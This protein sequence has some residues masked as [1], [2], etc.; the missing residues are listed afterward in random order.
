SII[1]IPPGRVSLGDSYHRFTHIAGIPLPRGIEPLVVDVQPA[2]GI[3]WHTVTLPA[4]DLTR[5]V[6]GVV[7]DP[8]G[9]A[10]AAFELALDEPD[11]GRHTAWTDAEGR[12]EL[13]LAPGKVPLPLRAADAAA[14]QVIAPTEPVY[15]GTLDAKVVVRAIALRHV[16][17]R[18]VD[19]SGGPIECHRLWILQRHE[20]DGQFWLSPPTGWFGWRERLDRG[21]R[22][23]QLHDGDYVVV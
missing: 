14:W 16:A 6:A 17:L 21:S 4:A 9:R 3:Q 22:S 1:G 11:R 18:A 19:A 12:F 13:R 15:A 20:R 5:A 8:D 23:L 2:A 7:V 10:V